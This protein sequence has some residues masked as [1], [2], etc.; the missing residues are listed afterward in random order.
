M[1][2]RPAARRSW[3]AAVVVITAA[4]ILLLVI[5][6]RSE[7]RPEGTLA[8]LDLPEPQP[9]GEVV[10][11]LP[12]RGGLRADVLRPPGSGTG[13]PVVVLVHG[14]CGDRADL[15]TFATAVA[16]AGAVVL[17]ADWSALRPGS[18]FEQA[19]QDVACA[20]LVAREHAAQFGGDPGRVTL[21]GWSDGAMAAMVVTAAGDRF[22]PSGCASGPGSVRPDAVVGLSGFYG[23]PLPVEGAY[24]NPRSEAFLGGPPERAARNWR[25]ATAHGWL[26]ASAPRCAGLLVGSDHVLAEQA[27]RYAAALRSAGHRAHLVLVPPAGDQSLLSSR[28][29]EG[30]A[31]VREVLTA[32]ELCPAT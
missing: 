21:V 10:G 11:T 23:W 26:A 15:G 18:Q 2:P 12:T 31:A 19:Y 25:E 32:V 7:P 8:A 9:P 20:V 13:L 1:S 5:G 4:V 27:R 30:R 24:V 28:T 6:G 14:C 17:N 16:G 3:P 22:S 29:A